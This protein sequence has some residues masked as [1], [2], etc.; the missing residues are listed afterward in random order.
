M[1]DGVWKGVKPK[2]LDAPVSIRKISFFCFQNS[3]YEKV[4]DGGE[5]KGGTNYPP[6]GTGGTRPPTA[7]PHPC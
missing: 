7:T 4:N 1:A 6:R 3:F 2:V 5:K